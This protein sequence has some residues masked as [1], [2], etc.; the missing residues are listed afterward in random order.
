MALVADRG[1]I[2]SFKHAMRGF[3]YRLDVVDGFRSSLVARSTDRFS[4][5]HD[6][7]ELPPSPGVPWISTRK[8]IPI[9]HV[10][11]FQRRTNASSA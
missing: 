5:N 6:V 11:R 2:R 4:T 10:S 9:S 8:D 7:A 1:A 3:D